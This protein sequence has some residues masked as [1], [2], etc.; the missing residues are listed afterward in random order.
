K[1]DY[2]IVAPAAIDCYGAT[3]QIIVNVTNPNGYAL[4]YSKDNGVTWGSSSTFSNL[5]AGTYN[6]VVRYTLG[7]T[8]C[9]DPAQAFI[10]AGPASAVTASAGVGSLAGC[11]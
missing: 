3:S 6:I 10:I 5:D 2:S 9:T 7:G 4:E 1:P 8:T 11:T